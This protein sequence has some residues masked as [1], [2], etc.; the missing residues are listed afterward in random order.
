MQPNFKNTLLVNLFGGPGTGKSTTMA[1]L[2]SKLKMAG[3]D[4]EQA[5]EFAKDKVWEGSTKVLGNQLYIFGKQH[6]RLWRLAGKVSCIVTDSPLLIALYYGKHITT[7]TFKNLVLE[8][9]NR[10]PTLNVFLKRVKVYNP[11]GRMQTEKEAKQIDVELLN[12]LTNSGVEVVHEVADEKA[13]KNLLPVVL[14]KL[15]DLNL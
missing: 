15:R 2:F 12:I 14:R 4:C 13:P 8:E 3:V 7:D 5:P 11:S 10:F 1:G 9:H 6:H